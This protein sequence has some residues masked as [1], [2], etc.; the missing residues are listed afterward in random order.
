MGCCYGSAKTVDEVFPRTDLLRS[1]DAHRADRRATARLTLLASSGEGRA[2]TLHTQDITGSYFSQDYLNELVAKGTALDDGRTPLLVM[3]LFLEAARE[4][5]WCFGVY[6]RGG[7]RGRDMWGAVYVYGSFDE[8]QLRLPLHRLQS[9]ASVEVRAHS[10]DWCVA[11]YVVSLHEWESKGS[12]EII[13]PKHLRAQPD[14]SDLGWQL[15]QVT[16][17]SAYSGEEKSVT[18]V[19]PTEQP[20]DPDARSSSI[21]LPTGAHPLH[22][23]PQTI[24]SHQQRSNMYMQSDNDHAARQHDALM[25]ALTGERHFSGNIVSDLTFPPSRNQA[26]RNDGVMTFASAAGRN[27]FRSLGERSPARLVHQPQPI[28]VAA[29]P[30]EEWRATNGGPPPVAWALGWPQPDWRRRS[31]TGEREALL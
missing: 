19:T 2:R 10:G 18:V 11:A 31:S 14:E 30:L 3:Q 8:S 24:H 28:P 23:N 5:S 7:S 26:I 22:L 27:E 6:P 29:S 4:E 17:P 1:P 13:Y 9:E 20:P 12:F 21:G 25:D 15:T 16:L